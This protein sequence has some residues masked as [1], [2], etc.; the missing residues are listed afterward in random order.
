MRKVFVSFFVL[1]LTVGV[2]GVADAGAPGAA[3]ATSV[4]THGEFAQLMMSRLATRQAPKL[5]RADALERAQMLGL[6]PEQWAVESVM[7]HAELAQV[8]QAAGVAYSP[9][10]AEA[11]LTREV[12][13]TVVS[14]DADQLRSYVGRTIG[15]A[16]SIQAPVTH[17]ISV[18]EF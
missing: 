4:L 11:P 14:Q 10:D 2:A 9:R 13:D 15:R 16:R 18:S 6:M 12:A 8:L 3:G 7:T 17:T 1:A 5:E